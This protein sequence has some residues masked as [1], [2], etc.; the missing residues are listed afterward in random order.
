[1]G[2]SLSFRGKVLLLPIIAAVALVLLA[3]STSVLG[4]RNR[5]QL[6][7]IQD[8]YAPSLQ[9]SQELEYR[10]D[11]LQRAFRDA[12]SAQDEDALE[13][14]SELREQI[15]GSFQARRENPISVP[16]E[17][18][19]LSGQF[20]AYYELTHGVVTKMVNGDEIDFEKLGQMGE[21]YRTLQERLSGIAERQREEMAAAYTAAMEANATSREVGIAVSIAG[22]AVVLLAS[23]LLVRRIV[24]PIGQLTQ[25][26][27]SLAGGNRET[28]VNIKSGDEIETL[29][30]S[31]N[32]MV[33]EL[34][35]SFNSLAELNQSLEQRV[36][37]RT[38][39]LASRN[40]DMQVVLQ[41][42][43]QGL[44]MVGADGAM[45]PERSQAFGEWFGEGKTGAF[46]K[47]MNPHNELFAETFDMGWAQF[48]DGFI[49]P[50]CCV[51]FMPRQLATHDRV[52][53][54]SYIP[55]SDDPEAFEGC[56]VVIDDVTEALEQEKR[57]QASRESIKVFQR[58]MTDRT[59][60][61]GFLSEADRLVKSI[62]P[63]SAPTDLDEL[64]RDIH[65]LKGNASFFGV[66]SLGGLCG[67]LES[68]IEEAGDDLDW[69]DTRYT[70]LRQQLQNRWTEVHDDAG[71]FLGDAS[72]AGLS[73]D[74]AERM[75]LLKLLKEK[76]ADAESAIR[77]KEWS[78][79]PIERSLGRFGERAVNL[80]ER[81]GKVPVKLDI[82]GGG[83]RVDPKHWAPFWADFAHMI[84]NAV[85]HGLETVDERAD[86]GKPD[87]AK[88]R[89]WAEETD[90]QGT[91][92]VGLSDDG[93]GIDWERVRASAKSRGLPYEH[94]SDLVE[95]LFSP[96]LTTRDSVSETSG[97][98]VGLCAVRVR[99]RA[100]GGTLTVSSKTMG[101]GT[102]WRF[103]FPKENASPPA[104]P[105]SLRKHPKAA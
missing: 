90:A 64:R 36:E 2:F 79:D 44:V 55:V 24:G 5:A 82:D 60:V 67:E 73:I 88:L 48:V 101:Q 47:A 45:S 37:K 72:D 71:Q 98:G 46:A 69:N 89:L 27:D 91:V 33:D 26:A 42:V 80:A 15:V 32:H 76:H 104:P 56:L 54:F 99:C 28:R 62:A 81:L 35:R 92:V 31:F 1:M 12:A 40:R 39:E 57:D 84:R 22:I 52:F 103:R 75:W 61:V 78:L 97:R 43:D 87:T 3:G 6:V 63:R 29:G 7:L 41:N 96:G 20:D 59:D 38:S 17:V 93:R 13:G 14:I 77:V 18:D 10:L 102:T 25:A 58:I 30:N 4:E 49:P 11:N 83:I 50:E 85:D 34:D 74:P 66:D 51:E 19:A 65:T 23:L 21:Q 8:G 70:E 94:H 100:M 68:H 53:S 105:P 9:A 16:E 95:A 86:A